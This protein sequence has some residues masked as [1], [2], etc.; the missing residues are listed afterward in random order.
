MASLEGNIAAILSSFDEQRCELQVSQLLIK[1]CVVLGF[2][3]LHSLCHSLMQNRR[4]LALIAGM[5]GPL[6]CCTERGMVAAYVRSY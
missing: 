3:P 2:I 5:L 6:V 1:N 4:L